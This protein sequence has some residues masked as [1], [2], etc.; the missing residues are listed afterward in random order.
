MSRRWLR[1]YETHARFEIE[2]AVRALEMYHAPSAHSQIEAY[3]VELEGAG[4]ENNASSNSSSDSVDVPIDAIFGFYPLLSGPFVAV[5]LESEPRVQ[6]HSAVDFRRATS[7]AV[8]PLFTFGKRLTPQQERDEAQ[9]LALLNEAFANHTFYF[10]H[11][12]DVTQTL[13][14][15]SALKPHLP[16]SS[17]GGLNN[18]ANDDSTSW[19]FS[20]GSG[21]SEVPRWKQADP[22]FFWN[23]GVV[24]VLIKAEAHEF[25]TPVMS[26]FI[27]M[28][29]SLSAAGLKFSL[30]FVSRRSR[31]RQGSRFTRRG[32]DDQGH[33]ANFV[34]TEQAL[35][36]DSGAM[37][38]FVQVRGSIPCNWSSH[39]SLK[40]AP[41][42]LVGPSSLPANRNAFARHLSVLHGEYEEVFMLNLIDKKK[43]QGRLGLI[44][45]ELVE[46]WQAERSVASSASTRQ[47]GSSNVSSD[48]LRLRGAQGSRSN[49]FEFSPTVTNRLSSG[50]SALDYLWFDFHKEC[51][52]MQWHH[53]SRLFERR[54]DS[55]DAHGW[56]AT[57]A[58]GKP[59]HTQ[60]GVTR[61]NC[62][63]NLDRTNVVQSVIARRA[64]LKILRE[65][66]GSI[67]EAFDDTPGA[68]QS[69]VGS[70]VL[71]L[72]AE[73]FG[74]LEEALK[75][76]WGDNADALS[77]LYSGTGALK[78]D[79]TRTG[80]RT[81]RGALSDG[82]NSTLRF[83]INNFCDGRR[84]DGVDLMLGSYTP[85]PEAPTPFVPRSK[86]L[87]LGAVVMQLVA[88]GIAFFSVLATALPSVPIETHFSTALAATVVGSAFFGM[89][90][91]QKGSGVGKRVAVHPML[92]ELSS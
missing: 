65:M 56:F 62:M 49:E 54:G 40:Y 46:H 14:R 61:T 71:E 16:G 12:H 13:Q 91:V 6:G 66:P 24:G 75:V 58:T 89:Y 87:T 79:F 32:A 53:L 23:R 29:P 44:F 72:Q 76:T 48:G 39:C 20:P 78:T 8:L 59:T 85:N 27:S 41:K 43:D 2:G 57:D 10:S 4:D 21:N 50:S 33:C 37:A 1:L 42:V 51:A 45:Q 34:E 74:L 7:V 3:F 19:L 30:L 35:L 15:L 81:M 86:Q 9:Y 17:S 5:I 63:D 38:S 55:L 11:T 28:R 67:S 69:G 70:S 36:F 47:V 73:H 80:K 83:Y 84:Q 68:T 22:R 64:V 90:S 77:F 92:S 25:I 26:A 18:S 31:F 52:K 82:W 88:L 60:R